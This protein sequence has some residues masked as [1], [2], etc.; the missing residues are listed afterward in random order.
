MDE[1]DFTVDKAAP[2]TDALEVEAVLIRSRDDLRKMLVESFSIR[3]YAFQEI[4]SRVETQHTETWPRHEGRCVKGLLVGIL[5]F[6]GVTVQRIPE[7]GRIGVC[8]ELV[9]V[10]Q[11]IAGVCLLF[12]IA[13]Q[14]D[15]VF[16]ILFSELFQLGKQLVQQFDTG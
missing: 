4:N 5:K 13:H 3:R 7:K 6:V 10:L 9:E 14:F 12:R 2:I 11:M 16:G 1:F 15:S 8:V